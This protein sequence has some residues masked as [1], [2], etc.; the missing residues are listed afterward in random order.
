VATGLGVLSVRP[1]LLTFVAVFL[2]LAACVAAAEN[3]PNGL[4]S[5]AIGDPAPDFKL[6]GV[7]DQEYTLQSFAD[8]QRLLIV[9]T[10]NHCPTAQAYESRIMQLHAD[11]RDKGVAL[12]AISP[13]DPQAIRLDELAFTD[14]SDSIE[15]MKLRA[16]DRGFE[17]P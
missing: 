3:H 11:Y 8:A 12:V 17:F 15:D 7:D 1:T 10:C 16:K 14:V 9:F 4:K 6:S 2:S 5:L 13:N